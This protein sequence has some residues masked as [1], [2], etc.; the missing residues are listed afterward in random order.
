MIILEELEVK[1][2]D[3][4][5]YWQPDGPTVVKRW[6]TTFT[7]LQLIDFIYH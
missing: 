2:L 7:T 1:G 5:W 4:A 6:R 3:T